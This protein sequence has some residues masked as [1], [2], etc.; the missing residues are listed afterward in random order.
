VEERSG[1]APGTADQIAARLVAAFPRATRLP[2]SEHVR[3][4]VPVGLTGLQQIVNDL[5]FRTAEDQADNGRVP[6]R[7]RG[8]GKEGLISRKPTRT[9]TDQ[10]WSAVVTAGLTSAPTVTR[11]EVVPHTVEIGNGGRHGENDSDED[12]V[13]A[14]AFTD[15]GVAAKAKTVVDEQVLIVETPLS[16]AAE[17]VHAVLAATTHPLLAGQPATSDERDEVSWIA[18]RGGVG[19]ELN[20]ALITVTLISKGRGDSVIPT[21]DL[22]A[23]KIRAVARGEGTDPSPSAAGRAADEVGSI[24]MGLIDPYEVIESYEDPDDIAAVMTETKWE[25]LPGWYTVRDPASCAS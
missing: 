4:A 25:P 19:D 11:R 5:E 6:V 16:A 21:Y 7:L 12:D 18:G 22:T 3:L 23:I 15:L 24:L 8:F 2:L 10:A 20:P 13:L 1:D 17:R 9:V 14:R